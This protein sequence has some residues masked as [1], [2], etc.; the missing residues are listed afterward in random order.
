MKITSKNLEAGQVLSAD[1]RPRRNLNLLLRADAQKV[2][3]LDAHYLVEEN[4][5]ICLLTHVAAAANI[6]LTEADPTH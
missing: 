1:K 2:L 4:S 6:R 3:I 5:N